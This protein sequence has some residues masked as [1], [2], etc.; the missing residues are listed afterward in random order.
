[1]SD[2]FSPAARST[3]ASASAP[4]FSRFAPVRID[5][6]ATGLVPSS[7]TAAFVV[8]APMS[9]PAVSA[10]LLTS[11]RLRDLDLPLPRREVL[12][13][14]HGEQS[15]PER[16]HVLGHGG[17]VDVALEPLL[18]GDD[19]PTVPRNTARERDLGFDPHAPQ[20]RDG[21]PRDRVVHAAQDVLDGLPAGE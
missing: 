2:G 21:P 9:M 6:F 17:H 3:P 10:K 15:G 12:R 16:P 11:P 13:P 5:A 19:H 1:M 18:Q 14:L 20:E 4:A 7:M 8:P